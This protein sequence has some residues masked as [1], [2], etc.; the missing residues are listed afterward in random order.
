MKLFKYITALYLDRKGMK[1]LQKRQYAEA[2][3]IFMRA[4]KLF[5]EMG[6]RAGM[7][8]QSGNL[9]MAYR[10][11]GITQNDVRYLNKGIEYGEQALKISREVED[12][13]MEANALSDL[14]NL[15]SARIDKSE[16]ASIVGTEENPMLH[17]SSEGI[18]HFVGD[19]MRAIEYLERAT[20][21]FRE[22]GDQ[23]MVG[24]SLFMLAVTLSMTGHRDRALT[25]AKDAAK[26]LTKTN[27]SLL[28]DVNQFLMMAER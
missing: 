23:E 27:S 6:D 28:K 4:G 16:P 11:L 20:D 10:V 24:S 17:L 26:I 21:A 8:K 18:Q 12:K 13:V 9:A 2:V 7:G 14:G 5:K 1:H 22:I 3:S 15:Y 19:S 25:V